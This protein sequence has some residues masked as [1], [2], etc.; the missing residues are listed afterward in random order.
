MKDHFLLFNDFLNI[1]S[2]SM[3]FSLMFLLSFTFRRRHARISI[4][5]AFFSFLKCSTAMASQLVPYSQRAS[6]S[7]W[8]CYSDQ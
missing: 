4:S 8:L 1:F 6:I 3:F 2:S 7:Y 5:T